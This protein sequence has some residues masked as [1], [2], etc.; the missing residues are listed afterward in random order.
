MLVNEYSDKIVKLILSGVG[1]KE[2]CKLITLCTS[3][4]KTRKFHMAGGIGKECIAGQDF[5]ETFD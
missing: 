5:R 2:I 4:Y 3:S 1:P